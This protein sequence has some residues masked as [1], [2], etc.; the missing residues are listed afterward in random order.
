MNVYNSSL[1][2]GY[3]SHVRFTSENDYLLTDV[4]NRA[5][6]FFF[7]LVSVEGEVA[8]SAVVNTFVDILR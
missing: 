5:A 3:R 6:N 7:P 8:S 2:S 1:K 4:L